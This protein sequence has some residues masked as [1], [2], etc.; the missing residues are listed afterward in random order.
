MKTVE[1]MERTRPFEFPL[2][3]ST[4]YLFVLELT[5]DAVCKIFVSNIHR[6]SAA[7]GNFLVNARISQLKK[8][9]PPCTP[10]SPS[11]HLRA[12]ATVTCKQLF[13]GAGGEKIGAGAVI[14]NDVVGR[15]DGRQILGTTYELRPSSERGFFHPFS[16][17][18]LSY[19]SPCDSCS[20]RATL[21]EPSLRIAGGNERMT[22][23][24]S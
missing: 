15:T 13:R 4:F 3:I 2:T 12:R 1:K 14:S 8:A 23:I 6:A 19:A 7:S 20:L 21:I 24:S 5:L 11:P 16:S 22:S 9:R 10:P 18:L 17:F